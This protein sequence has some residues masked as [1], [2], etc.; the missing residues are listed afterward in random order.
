MSLVAAFAAAGPGRSGS[1]QPT[2]IGVASST[3]DYPALALH[4]AYLPGRG[5]GK[6]GP[7]KRF[8]KI[9]ARF[10]LYDVRG[11]PRNTVR[12]DRIQDMDRHGVVAS[13]SPGPPAEGQFLALSGAARPQP[14]SVR[15]LSSANPVYR[16][17]V[18][19]YLRARGIRVARPRLTRVLQGDL[20]GDGK[21]EVLIAATSTEDGGNVEIRNFYSLVLLRYV[22]PNG[23]M[24]TVPLAVD[25]SARTDEGSLG[26]YKLLSCADLNG[27]G[28]REVV[29]TGSFYESN[30][31]A[32]FTFDGKAARRVIH[33]D[34]G[35]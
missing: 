1:S 30:S 20:N 19:D 29:V 9:R 7:V 28:R 8:F 26:R 4:G 18:S 23:S 34:F 31:L 3:D 24:G 21:N 22:N 2:L 15:Q 27:D 32:V 25:V 6:G 11:T 35:S 12:L 5:W 17:I 13:F 10:T 33:T 16:T 14:R